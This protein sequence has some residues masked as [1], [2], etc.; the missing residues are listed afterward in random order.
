MF[1]M[2]NLSYRWGGEGVRM[3]QKKKTLAGFHFHW[4]INARKKLPLRPK[5]SARYL[6]CIWLQSTHSKQKRVRAQLRRES[7]H[8][9][10]LSIDWLVL[11]VRTMILICWFILVTLVICLKKLNQ[12]SNIIFF[13][14]S[15]RFSIVFQV[16]VRV[17]RWGVMDKT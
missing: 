10:V 16:R 1:V 11:D 9:V 12:A 5:A 17:R 7:S 3:S 6:T 14:F 4:S 2:I 8:A 13:S 15:T